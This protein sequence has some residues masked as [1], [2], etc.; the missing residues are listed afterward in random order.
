MILLKRPQGKYIAYWNRQLVDR[1]NDWGLF[2]D[3]TFRF[4]YRIVNNVKTFFLRSK[5]QYFHCIIILGLWKL[6]QNNF[7]RIQGKLS[8]TKIWKFEI[9]NFKNFKVQVVRLKRDNDS[10]SQTLNLFMVFIDFK[11]FIKYAQ[12][13]QVI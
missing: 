13:V 2:F 10:S 9:V 12:Y 11:H 5:C 6:L 1:W 8:N 3:C 4:I 7:H